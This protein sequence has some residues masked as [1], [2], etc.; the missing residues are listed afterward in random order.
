GYERTINDPTCA[1]NFYNLNASLL[2]LLPQFQASEQTINMANMNYEDTFYMINTFPSLSSLSQTS[3]Q[4]K[5]NSTCTKYISSILLF[6]AFEQA[7]NTTY[8]NFEDT[9]EETNNVEIEYES[10]FHGDINASCSLSQI[11]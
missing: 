8:M 5:N 4:T 1:S 7:R 10:T 2:Y 3:G 11:Q 6:Q 9:S